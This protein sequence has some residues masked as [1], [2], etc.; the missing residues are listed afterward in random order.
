MCSYLQ[1]GASQRE[2]VA[3]WY[4]KWGPH[5]IM[6]Q[7]LLCIQ[8]GQPCYEPFLYLLWFSLWFNGDNSCRLRAFHLYDCISG[9]ERTPNNSFNIGVTEH[10]LAAHKMLSANVWSFIMRFDVLLTGTEVS[11]QFLFSILKICVIKSHRHS[12]FGPELLFLMVSSKIVKW[13][14]DL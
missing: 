13:F 4:L 10:S 2:F 1:Y 8:E 7:K 14:N 12:R 5:C 9:Q 6:G 11:S 3:G